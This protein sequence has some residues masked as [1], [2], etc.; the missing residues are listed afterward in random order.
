[1]GVEAMSLRS[2][3]K[4]VEGKRYSVSADGKPDIEVAT[5]AQFGGRDDLW[6]P[7]DL[8]AAS[9][10][11]CLL[12]TFISVAER[13][14]ASFVSYESEVVAQVRRV[15]G[16]LKFT[17]LLLRPTITVESESSV[18]PVRRAIDAAEKYCPVARSL[19]AEVK[20]EP[21]IRVKGA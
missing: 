4:W 17:T 10:N 2:M 15:E 8:F 11:A 6:S 14:N 1:M 12:S 20:V 9:L 3:V 16:A 21:T 13:L 7:L 18:E 5:P 19:N